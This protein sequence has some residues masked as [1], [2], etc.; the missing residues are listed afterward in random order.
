VKKYIDRARSLASSKTAKDT[1][2][3]F[4]GNLGS[5]FLGF[6]YTLLVARALSIEEFGIFSAA[7]NLIIILFSVTDVGISSGIVRF[8]SE[9]LARGK[10]RLAEKY[11][12]TGYVLRYST[13]IVISAVVAIFASFVSNNLLATSDKNVSYWVSAISLGIVSWIFSPYILQ[14]QKRFAASVFQD[15]SLGF[16]RLI[17]TAYLFYF[18]ELTMNGSF[19]AYFVSTIVA[20]FVNVYLIKLKFLRSKPER[21]EYTSLLKFSSWLGVNRV[22]SSVSGR[23][24]VQMLAVMLGATATGLYSIPSRLASFV[25]VL[26]AS[27][28]SVLAPRLSAFGDKEKEKSY[29]IKA[30]LATLPI[31]AGVIVWV[32]IAKPFIVFL[33]GEKYLPAVPIFQAL[34]IAMIPFV[35]TAPSVTAITYSMKKTIYIGMFSFFQIAAIFLANLVFIPKYGVFGPTITIGIVNTI[36]AIYSWVIIIKYYWVK[37]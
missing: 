15:L 35:L 17:L 13:A 36:L 33:F 29:I 23:L 6:L 4:S 32:I 24:D 31:V 7:T 34:T 19:L 9:S 37:K 14:A 26:T 18:A 3:L 21:K 10:E 8:I 27:F 28:S 16:S 11:I 22:I 1:Y 12:K 25:I 2:V 30:T 5:A 20:T